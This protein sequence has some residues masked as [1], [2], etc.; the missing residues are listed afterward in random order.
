[1]RRIG[2]GGTVR[3]VR[4]G[5]RRVLSLIAVGL[6]AVA[7]NSCA[8]S[9]GTEDTDGGCRPGRPHVSNDVVRPGDLVTVSVSAVACRPR[10]DREDRRVTLTWRDHAGHR[11]E[12]A[13]VRA[14]PSGAFEREVRIPRDS[15]LGGGNLFVSGVEVPCPGSASCAADAAGIGLVRSAPDFS[16]HHANHVASDVADRMQAAL[17]K[18]PAFV[19]LAI[20]PDGLELVLRTRSADVE[21]AVAHR[22]LAAARFAVAERDR[23]IAQEVRLHV[24]LIQHSAATLRRLTSRILEDRPWWS[25]R[26]V[27]LSGWGPDTATDSVRISLQHYSD[28]AAR[29][30]LQ[31][32]GDAVTVSTRDTVAVAG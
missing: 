24:R 16:A 10:F 19:E 11:A 15:A 30:L 14:F 6:V 4:S 12:L 17:E 28:A 26:H 27:E 25:S 29:L 32:Y 3:G 31:H 13:T 23:A 2:G 1:M 21:T 22:A 18:R 5:S 20:V 7:L 9:S 8:G